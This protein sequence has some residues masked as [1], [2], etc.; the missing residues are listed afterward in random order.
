M[1][2]QHSGLQWRE[3]VDKKERKKKVKSGDKGIG[4]VDIAVVILAQSRRIETKGS[5][6]ELSDIPIDMEKKDGAEQRENW[7]D[8]L[9]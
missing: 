1:F 7:E 9:P 3:N 2:H 5:W 6:K 4:N 8:S